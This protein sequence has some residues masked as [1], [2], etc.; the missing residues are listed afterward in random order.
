MNVMIGHG[1]F[2][3]DMKYFGPDRISVEFFFILSGYLFV[4]SLEKYRD[5]PL[6]RALWKMTVSKVKPLFIPLVIG[7]ISNAILNYLTSYNP[8]KVFRY[9]WY[10]PA[11]IIA[12][13]IFTSLRILIK[14]DKCFWRVVASIFVV[15]TLLRFSGSETLFF[16]DYLRSALAVS[17]GMLLTRIPKFPNN[18]KWICWMILIPVAITIFVIVFLRLAKDERFYEALLDIV[19]Y[20][21][22][23][24]VTFNI[25]FHSPILNY[26]GG[27]SFGIYAFQCPARLLSET[28][29]I[30]AWIPFALIFVLA[31]TEDTVKRILT[32]RKGKINAVGG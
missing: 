5:M 15:S 20:P 31:L 28:V 9:L 11:M 25:D 1:L 21:I 18:R 22:L 3:I 4:A 30:S 29:D 19:L 13:L 16:F 6:N 26:I 7:L 8:L 24:Y 10:I 2:P 32:Y 14:S 12:F 27:L 23:I 17:L